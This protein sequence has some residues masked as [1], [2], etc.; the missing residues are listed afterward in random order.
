[1]KFKSAIPEIKDALIE[2]GEA[3]PL[4]LPHFN[5]V[6]SKYYNLIKLSTFILN[7]F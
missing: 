5:A 4:V 1:M 3:V 6:Q 2:I 7:N